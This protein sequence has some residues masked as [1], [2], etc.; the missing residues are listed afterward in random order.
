TQTNSPKPVWP[1]TK[2]R[3]A[4]PVQPIAA[5]NAP[6]V[7]NTT[8]ALPGL[9]NNND[10]KVRA[11]AL[12]TE[13]RQLQK[14]GRL[15]E[16]RQKAEE[17]Q[18]L[19]VIFGPD[20]DRPEL[21]LLS[22]SALCQKRIDTLVQQANDTLARTDAGRYRRAESDLNQARQLAVGFH[23]DTQLIDSK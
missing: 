23:L 3:A 6:P 19:T 16:A 4:T 10:K 8:P 14:D 9:P 17:A 21:V 1:E 15:L 13:A 22:L 7:P 12:L 2:D 5:S 20:E 11:R 18:K